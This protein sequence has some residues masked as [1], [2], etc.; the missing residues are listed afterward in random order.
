[1]RFWYLF[2]HYCIL[3][4]RW[5]RKHRRNLRELRQRCKVCANADGFDFGVPDDVWAAVVPPKFQSR[6]VCLSCFDR[7]AKEK[8]VD[9][10][11][12]LQHLCFAGDQATFEFVVKP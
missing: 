7:F 3:P 1:M 5:F 12:S 4:V 11:D 6:V 9:Y 10:R 2:E 8:G